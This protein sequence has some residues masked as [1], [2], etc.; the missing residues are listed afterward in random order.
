MIPLFQNGR[1]HT[2][3]L[4]LLAVLNERMAA[5][6]HVRLA[7]WLL[8]GY[9]CLHYQIAGCIRFLIYR[10]LSGNFIQAR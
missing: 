7:G 2:Q 8:L 9:P 6:R 10:D 5:E 3:R 4:Q 1:M